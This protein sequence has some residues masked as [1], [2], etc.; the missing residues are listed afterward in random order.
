MM[1]ALQAVTVHSS[2]GQWI[3]AAGP[4]GALA[5]YWLIYRYYRNQD[6]S[7]AFESETLV[8]AK[9]VQGGAAKV[10]HIRKTRDSRIEGDNSSNHRVRVR[11]LH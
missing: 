1:V 9:P 7:H 6:K 4:L 2:D 11:R 5:T 10:D 3:L 8:E